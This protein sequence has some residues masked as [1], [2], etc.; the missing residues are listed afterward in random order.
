MSTPTG[1][2]E[3]VR[4]PDQAEAR[5]NAWAQQLADKA[6][7]YRDV[8]ERTQALRLTAASPDGAVRVT[9]RADGALDDLEFGDRARTLPLP[10]LAQQ[11]MNTVRR[12]QAQIADQVAAVMTDR[13]GD[14]DQQTRSLVLDNLRARF[15]EPDDEDTAAGAA[16]TNDRQADDPDDEENELW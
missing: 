15:P 16:A 9:V 2:G 14:E 10:D 12:A 5:M 11:V 6:A 7:R 8:G 4:D 3:P 1:F 13:L